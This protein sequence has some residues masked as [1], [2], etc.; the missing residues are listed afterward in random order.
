MPLLGNTVTEFQSD[1]IVI[2]VKKMNWTRSVDR[3]RRAISSACQQR[4]YYYRESRAIA[5][6]TAR[7][8][9]YMGALKICGSPWLRR[10][11]IFPKFVTGFCSDWV[12]INVLT[13]FEVRSFNRRYRIQKMW[14]VPVTDGRTDRQ[15]T[16]DRKTALCTKVHR[17]VKTTRRT[18]AGVVVTRWF[19]PTKLLYTGHGYCLDGWPSADK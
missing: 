7:C 17:A 15:T 5:K 1:P 18:P 9:L 13:K 16:C 19:R 11:L 3:G 10:R 12:Y 8:A 6:M 2:I 4:L 14:S